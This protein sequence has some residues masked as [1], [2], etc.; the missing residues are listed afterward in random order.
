MMDKCAE[1]FTI[2]ITNLNCNSLH[3]NFIINQGRSESESTL[4][5]QRELESR[6]EDVP[7]L[8]EQYY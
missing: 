1:M 6:V 2:N 7:M 5:R 3:L 8:R 4:P